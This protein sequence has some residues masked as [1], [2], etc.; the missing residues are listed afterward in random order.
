[1]RS[2]FDT[3]PQ[4]GEQRSII[5]GEAS[6]DQFIALSAGRQQPPDEHR[7]LGLVVD[8]RD[9]V[10]AALAAIGAEVLPVPGLDFRDPWGNRVQVVQYDDVQFTK[11]PGVLHGMGLDHLG[12]TGKAREELRRKGLA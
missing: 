10:R 12:K 7:H 1:M 4:R 9:A 5:S 3:R 6:G 11:A 2:W 8:D